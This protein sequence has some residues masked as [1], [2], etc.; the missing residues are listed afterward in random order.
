MFVAVNGPVTSS[1]PPFMTYSSNLSKS[2]VSP[3]GEGKMTQFWGAEIGEPVF[4]QH[5]K[6][7]VVVVGHSA[8]RF[9]LRVEREAAEN[10]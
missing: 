7:S 3:C 5:A 2:F 8:E 6:R 10:E 9:L 1:V 4:R